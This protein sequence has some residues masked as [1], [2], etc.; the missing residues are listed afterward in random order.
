MELGTGIFLSALV[1]AVILLYGITKDRWGWR[2]FVKR[3]AVGCLG[4]VLLSVLV[5]TGAYLYEEVPIP[6]GRQTEYAGIRLGMSQD[7]VLYIKGYP[8]AVLGEEVS[9]PQLKDFYLVLETSKLEKGSR[10]AITR[11][12]RT[13][14]TTVT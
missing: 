14:V 13:R 4:L 10:S 6:V 2:H 11:I 8:P 3:A 1:I 5:G 9:D 12:G 7:E